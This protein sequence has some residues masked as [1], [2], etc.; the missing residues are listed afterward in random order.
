MI[1]LKEFLYSELTNDPTI[2]SFISDR[3]FPQVAP[4]DVQE[5]FIVYNRIAP[6]KIDNKGIR[7]EYF[8]LSI[9]GKS[10]SENDSILWGVVDLFHGLKKS[11]VKHCDISQI[12]ETFDWDT[13]MTWTHVTVH[14]KTLEV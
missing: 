10:Q 11:P 2:S 6:G 3:V 1:N 12:D 13:K 5:P 9:W 4:N 14:I 7:N 8:Q